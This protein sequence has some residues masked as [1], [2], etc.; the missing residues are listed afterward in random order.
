MSLMTWKDVDPSKIHRLFYPQ[1]PVVITAEFEG[2][3]GGMSA[4]WCMPLSFNPPLVGVAIA[5]EHESYRII[6]GAGAFGVNWLTFS[7]A[8]QVGELGE[9]SAKD[10]R[11]KLSAV[12]FKTVSGPKTSQPLIQEASAAIECSIRKKYQ[13]GTHELLVGEVLTAS[14]N[15]NF[16]DYWDFS[17][18]NPLLYAGTVD[19]KE[20]NWLFKSG[21][22]ET[23]TVPLK[24]Q[25]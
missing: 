17:K 12:G 21:R 7:Y 2:R 4:I 24:H 19:G 10:Y 13:T 18:Y 20:K 23:V 1:V 25:M 11:N 9:I 16:D 6:T 3:V 22:G 5:P 8:K 15:G 14:V